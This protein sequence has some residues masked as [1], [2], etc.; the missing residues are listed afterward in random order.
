LQAD[1][2]RVPLTY[3]SCVAGWLQ[4]VVLLIFASQVAGIIGVNQCNRMAC[5]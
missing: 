2:D 5:F 4:T 1:L 3:T